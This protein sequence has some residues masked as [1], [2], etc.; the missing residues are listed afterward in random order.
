MFKGKK[1]PVIEFQ[2]MKSQRNKI[3]FKSKIPMGPADKKERKQNKSKRVRFE[4]V[5]ASVVLSHEILLE[6]DNVDNY[7]VL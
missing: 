1:I 2:F 7:K 5:Q 6:S 3:S 4:S